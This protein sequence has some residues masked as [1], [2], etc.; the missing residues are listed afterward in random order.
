MRLELVKEDLRL[1]SQGEIAAHETSLTS[2]LMT[3]LELEEQQYVSF[4][5]IL[6][7]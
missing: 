5:S 3:G 4:I 2:F 6:P 7:D 1:V